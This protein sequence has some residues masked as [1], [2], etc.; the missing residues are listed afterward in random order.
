MDIKQ[1]QNDLSNVTKICDS[2]NM[3]ASNIDITVD[4][5]I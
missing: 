2:F 1:Q 5:D 3:L 4:V